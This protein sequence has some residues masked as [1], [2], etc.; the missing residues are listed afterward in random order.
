[1]YMYVLVTCVGEHLLSRCLLL[2]SVLVCVCV[3]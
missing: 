1:M 2:Y 3:C